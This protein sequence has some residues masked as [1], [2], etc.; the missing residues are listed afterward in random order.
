ML[1]KRLGQLLYTLEDTFAWGAIALLVAI[2]TGVCL[3]V[4]MR[5]AFNSP[6]F[7]VVEMS[8]YALLWITF[9]GTG[10]TLRN[11]GH[12]RI[13]ILLNFLSKKWRHRL[14]L[15]SNLFG[16]IVSLVLLIFGISRTW[17]AYDRSLFHATITEFPTWIVMI[18][19]PLGSIPLL[20]RFVQRFIGHWRQSE[21]DADDLQPNNALE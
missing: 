4:V 1:V 14:G 16:V 13:E 18:F 6:I 2:T 5:Y 7:F 10:W 20:F 9:L 19:I 15:I 21:E 12:V 8:E 17:D 11:N 3:E